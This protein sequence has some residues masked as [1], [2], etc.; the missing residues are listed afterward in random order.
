M[1]AFLMQDS[2]VLSN[3]AI[4][5]IAQ[6]GVRARAM[7]LL[8]LHGTGSRAYGKCEEY[9]LRDS[10]V[11]HLRRS[12]NDHEIVEAA[13]R[14]VAIVDGHGVVVTCYHSRFTTRSGR[15]RA[16]VPSLRKQTTGWEVEHGYSY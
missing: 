7:D 11:R 8:L 15:R 1:T 5:R 10:T 12:G 2:F 4:V 9:R 14:L 16:Q 6:R 13:R 3:H